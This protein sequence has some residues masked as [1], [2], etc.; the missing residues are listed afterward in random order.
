MVVLEQDPEGTFGGRTDVFVTSLVGYAGGRFQSLSGTAC[1]HGLPHTDYSRLGHAEA[2]SITLNASSGRAAQSQVAA[3]AKMYFEHGFQTLG[4]G[5][6]QR[7][8]PQDTGAE[9]RN[10]IGLPGGMDNAELWPIFVSANV[11]GMTLKRGTGGTKDDTEDEFIVYVYDSMR[12]PFFRGEAYHQFH[13]N[14]VIKRPVPASYTQTLK[15]VQVR[16]GRL[17]DDIG[18]TELPFNEIVLLITFSFA[19]SLGLG[20]VFIIGL[21]PPKATCLWRVT[22]AEDRVVSIQQTANPWGDGASGVHR[23]N[24]ERVEDC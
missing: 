20:V 15:E 16:N 19:L 21:L 9:Y 17:D 5:R 8:D 3:L 23:S 13:P 1:Y 12:F 18:C 2:V 11:H 22:A 10:V 24:V 4:D 14:S 7:L 6:R